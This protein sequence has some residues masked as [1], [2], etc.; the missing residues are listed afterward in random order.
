METRMHP[1]H[2]E[3]LAHEG[4]DRDVDR[5]V[6][7]FLDTTLA[8]LTKEAPNP[9]AYADKVAAFR[10]EHLEQA[11]TLAFRYWFDVRAEHWS[12]QPSSAGLVEKLAAADPRDWLVHEARAMSKRIDRAVALEGEWRGAERNRALLALVDK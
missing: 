3:L 2:I 4:I 7:A 11:H 1:A 5:I 10:R 8:A 12:H 9:R 6:R